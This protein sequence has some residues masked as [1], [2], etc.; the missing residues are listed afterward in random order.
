MTKILL[1]GGTGTFGLEFTKTILENMEYSYINLNIFSRDEMKQWYMREN[2][3]EKYGSVV[4]NRINFV[5]GDVREKS[6][7]EVACHDCD[8]VVHAAATKIV[9]SSEKNPKQC[10][11]TNVMGAINIC[12]VTRKSKVK[13]LVALSTDKACSPV[14]LYGA[15]KLASDKIILNESKL[16]LSNIETVVVRYG[17]VI[18]SRG[19]V[20]PFFKKLIAEDAQIPVTH[21]DM[22]RFLISARSAV[23]F[24]LFALLKK[25]MFIIL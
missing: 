9:P 14:N 12:E 17:N 11:M 10:I 22:T 25:E 24:V 1:T 3:L 18:S 6:D 20:I 2:L 16:K 15:S 23:E 7:L 13:R 8:L 5:L 19:S 4:D 21:Q